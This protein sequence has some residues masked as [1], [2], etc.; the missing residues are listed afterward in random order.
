MKVV[1]STNDGKLIINDH[2]G[3]GKFFDVYE[4]NEESEKFLERRNNT[5]KEER[6]HGDPLKA[7]GI[8][9]ILSDADILV[10]FQ[11]GPNIQRMKSKFLTVISR[12]REIKKVIEIIKK[13]F[14]KF[15]DL[16]KEKNKIVIINE[17]EK[18]I[19]V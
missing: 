7:A 1:F 5:S 6:F 13:N 10:G 16:L 3:E 18:I 19:V 14:E 15:Q 11:M 4:I 8:G 9:K 12:Y 2:F 17:N